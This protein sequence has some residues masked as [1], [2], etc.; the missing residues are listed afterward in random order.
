MKDNIIN[1]ELLK[2]EEDYIIEKVIYEYLKENYLDNYKL[3]ESKH[4]D[5]IISIIKS[6]KPNLSV[7]LPNNVIIR[8]DYKTLYLDYLKVNLVHYQ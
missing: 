4:I 2:E 1:L 3:I 7:F 8:K 6:N 5:S